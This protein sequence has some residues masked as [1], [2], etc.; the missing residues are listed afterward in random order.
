[1][2]ARTHLKGFLA[3]QRGAAALEFAIVGPM[4]VVM[5]LGLCGYGGYFW[6][7][8]AV[9]QVTNDAARAAM[10]GLDNTER[11]AL[12]TAALNAEIGDYVWL[13]RNKATLTVT[14][15]SDRVTVAIS[16]NAADTPFWSMKGLVPMPSSTISRSATVRLGG[17]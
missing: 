5:L 1:M 16:Y 6:M 10:A 12:A 14:N 13:E 9:Q 3:E 11:T 15:A 17:Y 4:F 7:S 8:H 2:R